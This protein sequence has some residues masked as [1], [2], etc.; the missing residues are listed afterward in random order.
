MPGRS[1]SGVSGD[2]DLLLLPKSFS[3]RA[4][5]KATTL[6]Q[7]RRTM[8]GGWWAAPAPSLEGTC[9]GG[10]GTTAPCWGLGPAG[11]CCALPS[12]RTGGRQGQQQ[13]RF[14]TL[15][16]ESGWDMVSC[17]P[18]PCETPGICPTLTAWMKAKGMSPRGGSDGQGCPAELPSLGTAP[19]VLGT[20]GCRWPCPGEVSG[21]P[22]VPP[23]PTAGGVPAD[24]DSHGNSLF[25]WHNQA[26]NGL[27]R[28]R[29]TRS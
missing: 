26:D 25:W 9:P 8:P 5:G 14:L 19:P 1:R 17:S 10:P 6:R 29:G 21:A 16:L 20:A 22:V 11:F 3:P 7:G 27:T 24:A 2:A 13:P 23:S 4:Q 15:P 28:L 12:Q 18:W